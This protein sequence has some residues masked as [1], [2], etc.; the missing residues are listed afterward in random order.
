MYKPTQQELIENQKFLSDN[1]YIRNLLEQAQAGGW[2]SCQTQSEI[3][4][5][6]RIL[7]SEVE[8]SCDLFS[9]DGHLYIAFDAC[10]KYTSNLEEFLIH[11]LKEDFEIGK[12]YMMYGILAVMRG[13][14]IISKKAIP[15]HE[16]D[17]NRDNAVG[18][19]E[20][21]KAIYEAN[22]WK[23]KL[24]EFTPDIEQP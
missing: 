4:H 3:E 22:A 23:D 11:I 20:H 2:K 13:K 19:M 21:E 24:T 5:K 7:T 14:E 1:G 8:T 15:V 16:Q 17:E 18:R 12:E 6:L 9:E 10:R